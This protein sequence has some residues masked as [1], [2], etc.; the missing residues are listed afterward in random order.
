VRQGPEGFV[1]TKVKVYASV[2]FVLQVKEFPVH[3][4]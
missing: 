4:C 3:Q 1:M 2:R